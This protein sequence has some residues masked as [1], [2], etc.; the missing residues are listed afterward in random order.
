MSRP[1]FKIIGD[2]EVLVDWRFVEKAEGPAGPWSVCC[3]LE[4]EER[5]IEEVN[6]RPR[7]LGSIEH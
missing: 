1:P 7:N 4:R 3:R 5:R 2:S 6:L